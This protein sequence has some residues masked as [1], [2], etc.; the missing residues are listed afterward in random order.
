MGILIIQRDEKW[1]IVVREKWCIADK[2]MF[3][4]LTGKI[5]DIGLDFLT[6]KCDDIYCCVLRNT[7]VEFDSLE[8]MKKALDVL[9]ELKRGF[10]NNFRELDTTTKTKTTTYNIEGGTVPEYKTIKFSDL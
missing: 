5:V 10:G 2:A 3:I 8:E 1:L 4:E 9:I 7:R 6:Q